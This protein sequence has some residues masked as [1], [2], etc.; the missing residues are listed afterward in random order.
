MVIMKIM[1][2]TSDNGDE[3]GN[4]GNSFSENFEGVV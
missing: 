1:I 3:G 4:D 2:F